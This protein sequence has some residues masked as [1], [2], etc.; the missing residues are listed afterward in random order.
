[1]REPWA[2]GQLPALVVAHHKQGKTLRRQGT[3][4]TR[5]TK[6]LVSSYLRYALVLVHANVIAHRC[7]LK[8]WQS[9]RQAYRPDGCR[10]SASTI[11]RYT[12]VRIPCSFTNAYRLKRGREIPPPAYTPMNGIYPAPSTCTTK[13]RTHRHNAVDMARHHAGSSPLKAITHLFEN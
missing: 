12:K 6:H 3:S 4:S 11:G 7:R 1:M 9:S 13:C 8:A 5:W 10:L 2:R